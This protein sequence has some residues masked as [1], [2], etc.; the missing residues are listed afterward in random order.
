MP[1]HLKPLQGV[2]FPGAD[3]AFLPGNVDLLLHRV[4]ALRG[5]QKLFHTSRLGVTSGYLGYTHSILDTRFSKWHTNVKFDIMERFVHGS[6]LRCWV[7]LRHLRKPG[8]FGE[9]SSR[10]TE[11]LRGQ[12]GVVQ[13]LNGPAMGHLKQAGARTTQTP[14]SPPQNQPCL[15]TASQP[16][17]LRPQKT[18][19]VTASWMKS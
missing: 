18:T 11:N 13:S 15:A 19:A 12:A 14:S 2:R 6:Q 17:F 3:A 7:Y 5:G 9:G 16:L 10:R 4:H 1:H 8:G